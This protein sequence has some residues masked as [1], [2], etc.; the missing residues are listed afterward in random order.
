VKS[1]SAS[2]A[3]PSAFGAPPQ[4]GQWRADQADAVARILN[5]DKR[6]TGINAP[7]GTGKSLIAM[8]IALLTK[9]RVLILTSTRSLADLYMKDWAASG[10]FDIRGQR[11]YRCVAVAEDGVMAHRW[12][13]REVSVE[14]APCHAGIWCR[15]RSSGCTY[16]DAQRRAYEELSVLT[17]YAYWIAVG[18][19]G[20]EALGAFDWII[21]DEADEAD[22]EIRRALH[23]QLSHS[24]IRELLS[25]SPLAH[26]A[27]AKSWRAWGKQAR[28]ACDEAIREHLDADVELT[29]HA[30]EQL[31]ELR[32]IKSAASRITALSG[33]WLIAE[34]RRGATDFDPVWPAPYAEEL[35][36][37]GAP[38][39][40]LMSATL[41]RK[42]MR[43]LG[44][45]RDSEF[46][47]YRSPFPISNRPVYIVDLGEG[48][49]IRVDSRTTDT[50]YGW[51][52]A[53]IDSVIAKRLDRKILIHSVSYRLT[54]KILSLS[55]Y[56]S[57]MISHDGSDEK[58]AALKSFR[59]AK[60]GAA[61]SILIS[62]GVS[63]GESFPMEECETIII[64]KIP[65]LDTRDPIAKRRDKEDPSYSG[66]LMIK[67]L[68]QSCGRHVRSLADRGEVVVLDDHARWAVP[69]HGKSGGAPRAFMEAL[70]WIRKLPEP[71]PKL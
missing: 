4:F 18:Q 64:P 22:P 49:R 50:G 27:P 71:L 30:A 55:R 8:M 43:I 24:R 3:P 65:F 32:D 9:Q 40:V 59:A 54:Q 2:L 68:V 57:L 58:P 6:F 33:E 34:P 28:A 42:D 31:R 17:N 70:K 16:F 12:R 36:Y 48:S 26:D 51:L 20:G 56:T 5:S 14:R 21:M 23:M 47:E 69:K 60:P 41:T 15:L 62:P 11:N 38:R 61:N 66:H 67:K 19:A 45:D 7:C 25:L 35:L 63:V 52:V 29:D 10:L 13:G 1:D 53:L 37:R 46:I 44:A 39:I